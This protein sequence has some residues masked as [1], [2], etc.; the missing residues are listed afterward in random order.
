MRNGERETTNKKQGMRNE[1]RRTVNEKWWLDITANK[2]REAQ[3]MV[4]CHI[5]STNQI[6]GIQRL[7]FECV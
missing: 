6:R 7:H 2:K 1:E 5:Y 3:V 4:T